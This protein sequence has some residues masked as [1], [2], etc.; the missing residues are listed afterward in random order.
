MT[1]WWPINGRNTIYIWHFIPCLSFHQIRLVNESAKPSLASSWGCRIFSLTKRRLNWEVV[2]DEMVAQGGTKARGLLIAPK[3][4]NQS[5]T[6]ARRSSAPQNQNPDTEQSSRG[7]QTVRNW[8]TS[9]QTWR[10]RKRQTNVDVGPSE[11][12][13]QVMIRGNQLYVGRRV[14][15]P[16]IL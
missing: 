5:R 7:R 1:K 16:R 8:S 13:L 4:T 9:S 12:L 3:Q 11:R 2:E 14:L 10:T 15:N 6:V